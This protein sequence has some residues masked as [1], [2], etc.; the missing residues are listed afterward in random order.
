MA[1][2]PELDDSNRKRPYKARGPYKNKGIKKGRKPGTWKVGPDPRM[3]DQYIAWLK[4]KSQAA[5]RGE[6]HELTFEQWQTLW[7]DNFAWENRGR[8]NLCVNLVRQDKEKGWSWDNV[9]MVQR[10]EY[11][12]R[13][14]QERLG[15]TY[16]RK[17]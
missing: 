10:L 15:K 3:H 13:L 9:E 11:L 12:R 14:G 6:A 2:R 5:Y 16:K 17:K 8:D 1:A 4:H 7:N